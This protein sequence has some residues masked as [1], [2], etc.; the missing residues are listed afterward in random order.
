MKTDKVEDDQA[1]NT[2]TVPKVPETG[3][4][5][6]FSIDYNIFYQFFPRNCYTVE[7]PDKKHFWEQYK[8]CAFCPL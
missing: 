2:V 7:S 5:Q 4:I 3:Y 6:T 1:T 8:F